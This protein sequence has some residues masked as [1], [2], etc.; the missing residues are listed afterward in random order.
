MGAIV[1]TGGRN[2]ANRID[3]RSRVPQIWHRS[4]STLPPEPAAIGLKFSNCDVFTWFIQAHPPPGTTQRFVG[5]PLRGE[6]PV[7]NPGYAAFVH[8]GSVAVCSR[9][10]IL[11]VRCGS[12]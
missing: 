7:R 5:H 12:H 9:R 11:P 2:P 10:V 4:T 3:R 8:P 6:L 1:L